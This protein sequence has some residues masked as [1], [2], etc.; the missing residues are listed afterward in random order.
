LPPGR[1]LLAHANTDCQLIY[2]SVLRYSG[3]AVDCVDTVDAALVLLAAAHFD[4][5]IAD[6]YLPSGDQGD[7]D[8]LVRRLRFAAYSSHLPAVVL[9]AWITEAHRNVAREAGADRFLPLPITPRHLVAVMDELL[10][11]GH[12]PNIP[13]AI[14]EDLQNRPLRNGF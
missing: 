8:C 13:S 3:Y 9:T 14:A 12:A 10:A 1:I 4:A 2:G 6:L 7:D 5:V 11:R